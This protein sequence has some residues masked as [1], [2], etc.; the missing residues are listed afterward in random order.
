MRR[1]AYVKQGVNDLATVRPDLVEEWA[2]DNPVKPN[3]IAAGSHMW[4]TWRCKNCG[5]IW[6]ARVNMRTKEH[7]GGGT[8]CPRCAG[9][10]TTPHDRNT[11]HSQTDSFT[12]ALDL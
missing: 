12:S 11:V 8:N 6:Q 2:P 1:A 5:H 4:A 7:N 9:F 10:T 3:K